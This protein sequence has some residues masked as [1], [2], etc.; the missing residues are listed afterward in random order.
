MVYRDNSIQLFYVVNADDSYSEAFSLRRNIKASDKM[1]RLIFELPLGVKAKNIR[2]DLGE[3]GNENDS[4]QIQNIRFEYKNRV[5]NG[6]NG[7][8]KAWFK[9]KS[10]CGSGKKQAA[11]SFKESEWYF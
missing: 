11:L 9:F 8:Y 10:E 3:H 1:Q 2:I 7:L 6:S 5:I 4:L